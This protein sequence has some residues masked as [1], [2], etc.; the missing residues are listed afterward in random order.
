MCS[1]VP[2]IKHDF[3]TM[4]EDDTQFKTTSQC[5]NGFVTCKVSCRDL[6]YINFFHYVLS[7]IGPYPEELD[8]E[9]SYF[10]CPTKTK[11]QRIYKKFSK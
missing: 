1:L 7:T 3:V 2:I 5:C 6:L 10:Q 4:V 11:I 8:P 9:I